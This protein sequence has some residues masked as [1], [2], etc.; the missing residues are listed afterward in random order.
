MT[1]YPRSRLQLRIDITNLFL[2][3][4][5]LLF[6]TSLSF[7][8]RSAISVARASYFGVPISVLWTKKPPPS[9]SSLTWLKDRPQLYYN[10]PLQM[11]LLRFPSRV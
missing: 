3:T 9:L 4:L 10:T 7:T 6:L 2:L 8:P 1:L 5:L 11:Q